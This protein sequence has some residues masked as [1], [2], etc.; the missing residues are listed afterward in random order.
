[1]VI[2]KYIVIHISKHHPEKNITEN[3]SYIGLCTNINDDTI[4]LEKCYHINR[5]LNQIYPTSPSIRNIK[6]D[7]N[8]II[9]VANE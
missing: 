2:G 6:M 7:P 3:I 4:T 5:N 1:M 8:N 9:Y